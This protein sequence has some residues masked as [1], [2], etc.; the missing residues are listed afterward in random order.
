MISYGKCMI[1]LC[2]WQTR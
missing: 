1:K 2:S